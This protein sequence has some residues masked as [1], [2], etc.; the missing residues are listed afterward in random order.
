MRRALALPG[1]ALLAALLAPAA[2]AQPP[3]DELDQ[4]IG[5]DQPVSTHRAVLSLGHVDIGPRYVDGVWTLMVHDDTRAIVDRSVWREL[6]QT[7]FQVSDTAVLPVPEDPSY[8]FIGEPGTSVYV[9]PQVQNPD[10]VWVGWNT[11][12]PDVMDT[13][14]GGVTLTLTSLD[15]PG[16]LFVY[17]QAGNFGAADVLWDSTKSE[18][19]DIWV[20]VNTHTHANWVF[21]EPGVYL[22][23]VEATADL[24][25]GSTVN[26][27]AALRFA[28]GNATDPEGA[29]AAK[30]HAVPSTPAG[31]TRAGASSDPAE[32]ASPGPDVL[33][34]ALAGVA[35]ILAAGMVVVVVRGRA[36]KRHAASRDT[37]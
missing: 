34:L 25:D 31:A 9:L 2:L 28:V 22:A 26:G 16:E 21:T 1:A 23:Q 29:F 12:D 20:E 4:T 24:V 19:Q 36:A 37:P 32:E 8:S 11:Q 13:I 3:S 10:V 15:G 33:T 27:T 35:L 6:D 5:A 30:E 17:L 18:R 7:V 14:E